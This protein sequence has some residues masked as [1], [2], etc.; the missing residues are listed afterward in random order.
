MN[1]QLTIQPNFNI[2]DIFKMDFSHKNKSNYEL[3]KSGRY[4]LYFGLKNI[5]STNPKLKNVY[6]PSFV[7][8]QVLMPLNSLKLNLVFYQID[9]NLLIDKD[10]LEK[11]IN[12]ECIIIVINYF[13]FSSDWEFFDSLKNKTSCTLI[14]DNCHS[15]FSKYKGKELNQYGDLS[16]NSFRKNL[17]LL[18][19]SQLFY[20]NMDYKNSANIKMRSPNLSELFYMMR[21]FKPSFIK[22]RL[23]DTKLVGHYRPDGNNKYFFDPS[24][25]NKIDLISGNL[26]NNYFKCVHS[27]TSH[28]QKNYRAWL[29]YLPQSEFIFINNL[30]LDKDTTPYVF[31]CI[32]KNEDIMHKWIQWGNRRNISIINWSNKREDLNTKLRLMLLFPII[33][34]KN[35]K[36]ILEDVDKN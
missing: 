33:P 24:S 6:I 21:S 27:I 17:P 9:E 22:S 5:L 16:F 32:A 30:I 1:K 26:F 14:S 12:S 31:P 23:G 28:R 11:N 35:V 15:L 29:N 13:G 19:G 7:C 4:A 34:D 8:P 25:E 20:N 10:F 36:K 2:I 3:Y 18:S